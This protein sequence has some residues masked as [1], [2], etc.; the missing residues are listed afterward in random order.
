MALLKFKP[1][2]INLSGKGGFWKQIGM[3]IIGTTI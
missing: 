1:P 3:I 2:R